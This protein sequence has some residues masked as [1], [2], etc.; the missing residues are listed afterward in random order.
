MPFS[1][2]S[3]ALGSALLLA[4]F[5]PQSYAQ[6]SQSAPIAVATSFS[7][8]A[9]DA[10]VERAMRTFHVP[11]VAVGILIDGKVVY[12]KGYGVRRIGSSDP[13]DADTL[14][15]VGSITKSFTG[16][17]VAAMVDDGK[18]DFDKPVSNYL[19]G[20]RLYDPITTQLITP[21]DLLGHR[22]GLPR[23]DFI[24]F[25]TWLT[26]DQF[27]ERLRYL[28]PNHTLRETFQYNNLMYVVAG[29]L[30]GKAN[31]TSW[32]Q[33]F[34]QR[35]FTPLGMTHSN[36]SA[37][38]IQQTADFASPH[39]VV[40]DKPVVIPFYDYQRFGI[41]P[42]GAVNSSVN[43][44]LKYLAFHMGDGTAN[45]KQ[46]L[47]PA[48]FRQIHRP[49]TADGDLNYAMGWIVDHRGSHRV[50]LH[51][52]SINGFSAQMS[53]IP[54]SHTAIIV[55][56]NVDSALP[57]TVANNFLNRQLGIPAED[58]I[59]RVVQSIARQHQREADAAKTFEV[60]RLPDAPASLPLASYI[61]D[62][63][64]PAFGT[65]HVTAEGEKLIVHFDALNLTLTHYNYDTFTT[66]DRRIATFHL[67]PQGQPIELLLSLEP[68]V[69]PFVFT[70]KP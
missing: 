66:P 64:H 26:P 25:S 24:R 34:Q 51:D 44:M 14:F 40:D 36:T 43:D 68:A 55:L 59:E 67:S 56:N 28:E 62:W 21:R 1:S 52:G 32:E 57:N 22:S 23:H 11:G 2:R 31:G 38:E 19:P 39:D 65:V 42:N 27:V 54:D 46:V 47:S 16:M 29:Y 5:T 12:T 50:L 48:Q 33:L 4:S 8:S 61:G 49:I 35:I 45:G 6:T 3:L 53:L 10:D 13:V 58:Q 69:K 41:G 18:L 7:A 70:R 20:F 60:A 30:A 9:V 17:A 63:F 37:R 15:D